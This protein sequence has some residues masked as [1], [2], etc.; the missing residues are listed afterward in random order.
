M[1]A[2]NLKKDNAEI[3]REL[4]ESGCTHEQGK[5]FERDN[6][7]G[8]THNTEAFK[9]N[10]HLLS[11]L[12]EEKNAL[13]RNVGQLELQLSEAVGQ[14][15][16]WD[17]R[18][19]VAE[20]NLAILQAK[21]LSSEEAAKL[22]Q[23]Q[24]AEDRIT[25][26]DLRQA[27]EKD[28]EALREVQSQL[29][30]VSAEEDRKSAEVATLEAMLKHSERK[31]SQLREEK[32]TAEATCA[33]MEVKVEECARL[34]NEL[35]KALKDLADAQEK[36]VGLETHN[37]SLSKQQEQNLAKLEKQARFVEE[38]QQALQE[39][40]RRTAE[41]LQEQHKALTEAEECRAASRESA[42]AAE[43][44]VKSAQIQ[45]EDARDASAALEEAHRLNLT[46][47]AARENQ[48]REE[49]LQCT[50]TFDEQ[51]DAAK[52]L[53]QKE[54][55]AMS[56]FNRDLERQL[57]VEKDSRQATE[58]KRQLLEDQQNGLVPSAAV[59][60]VQKMLNEA[61]RDYEGFADNLR[62]LQAVCKARERQ[63]QQLQHDLGV[64]K[65]EHEYLQRTSNE[66]KGEV[67][68]KS[69]SLQAL[70]SELNQC[71][72]RLERCKCTSFPAPKDKVRHLPPTGFV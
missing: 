11:L 54:L 65:A 22:A 16:T 17:Q 12:Q 46:E 67:Q 44:A 50:K 1:K 72:V 38:L 59:Q 63:I 26:Q 6:G 45:Q 34:E 42:A 70:E 8:E 37:R 21:L 52:L 5:S 9:E 27:H 57:Q 41:A 43:A 39:A 64:T 30:A 7:S 56:D 66:L 60:H 2:D 4:R 24:S 40:E 18:N 68:A 33:G 10:L 47:A 55:K 36:R 14:L 29:Q 35:A 15:K 32:V 25:L 19:R 58:Q 13:L 23:A 48:L 53:F 62:H 20:E 61:L 28:V 31:A 69:R 71:Y 51:Y 3:T 49:L